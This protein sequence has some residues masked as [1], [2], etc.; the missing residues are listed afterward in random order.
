[1]IDISTFDQKWLLPFIAILLAGGWIWLAAHSASW[2]KAHAGFLNAKQQAMLLDAEHQIY[3]MGADYIVNQIQATGD[4]VHPKVD[5]WVMRQAIQM[6][7]D[8]PEIIAG[9]PED[10]AAKIL[11]KLPQVAISTDTTGATVKT[12]A[13]E[14]RPLAKT[15]A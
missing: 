1:M 7:L 6:A 10:V 13:V 9:R 12:E 8:H 15:G 4:K 14:T 5:S 3:Q 11:A 2:L